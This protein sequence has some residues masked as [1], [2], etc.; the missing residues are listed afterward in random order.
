[1]QKSLRDEIKPWL[2]NLEDE[3]KREGTI[4]YPWTQRV[5][6][7]TPPF[8]NFQSTSAFYRWVFSHERWGGLVIRIY[9]LSKLVLSPSGYQRSK[10]KIY[11]SSVK[12]LKTVHLFGRELCVPEDSGIVFPEI[13][14]VPGL[15]FSSSGE[16][17]GRGGGFGIDTFSH[18]M[19]RVREFVTRGN[20]EIS[21]Q[22]SLMTRLF[23]SLWQKIR[24]WEIKNRRISWTLQ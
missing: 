23:L 21:C 13:L 19:E 12:N 17:L 6:W 18:L 9:G 11:Q 3:S 22:L 8:R 1:M 15:S 7:S 2:R 24:F 4:K 20:W 16:R 14:V 5:H 10:N